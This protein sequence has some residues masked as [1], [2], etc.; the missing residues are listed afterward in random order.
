MKFIKFR[1]VLQEFEAR[2]QPHTPGGTTEGKSEWKHYGDGTYRFKVS[3]RNIPLPD[4][5]QIDV[6]VDE[7]HLA[8][9]EVINRKSKLD[10]EDN[11]MS[12]GLPNIRAGQKV[13]IRC[14][15]TILAEGQYVEE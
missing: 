6:L 3:V 15:A 11:R 4:H 14:G 9:L 13:Q 1:R 8:T 7:I 2:I 5:S 10:T 12:L